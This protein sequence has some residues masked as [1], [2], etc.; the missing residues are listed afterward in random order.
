VARRRI[1]FVISQL[2]QGGAERYLYEL[3]RHVDRSRFD[4]EVLAPRGVR[5]HYYYGR[6][7]ELG[8]Q[9]HEKLPRLRTF[10][11]IAPGLA[12]GAWFAA[13]VRACHGVFSRVVLS[14]FFRPDDIIFVIQIE[15]YMV[16]QHWLDHRG[17]V[18][19][20]LMSNLAQYRHNPYQSCR[21]SGE[22]FVLYDPTQV[23]DLRGTPCEN[24]ET[25]FLPLPVSVR[26]VPTVPAVPESSRK[27]AVF[28]RLSPERRIDV[29]IET[30]AHLRAELG[31]TLHIYGSGDPKPYIAIA[32]RLGVSDRVFFEGHRTDMARALVEERIRLVWMTSGDLVF[33][34][35]AL[36]VAAMGFPML[37]LNLGRERY[38]ELLK[39]SGGR[40]HT[41][42]DGKELAAATEL[43]LCD[44]SAAAALGRDL[45]EYVS[46]K[47][48]SSLLV[49]AL[50]GF[51]ERISGERN[52]GH[53]PAEEGSGSMSTAA[54]S[55]PLKNG[56]SQ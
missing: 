56:L 27:I 22:R 21:P 5:T 23:D 52:G 14:R 6:I 31:A 10:A 39:Q 1:V 18:V 55:S 26:D 49:P 9:I 51:L 15:N 43:P 45:R 8:V 28:V 32:E 16:L 12:A 46:E 35:A 54:T 33:G 47:H 13:I 37:V 30:F 38:H 24:V 19:V 11:G 44:S 48:E 41:F 20:A 50:E 29:F 53:G 7:R 34:Y 17:Q 2:R 40:V 4:V 3:C 36:E 42:L 25:F